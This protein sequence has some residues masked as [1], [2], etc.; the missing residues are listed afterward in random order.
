MNY[1]DRAMELALEPNDWVERFSDLLLS[2]P[3]GA[4]LVVRSQ[5]MDTPRI[6]VTT[7][8]LSPCHFLVDGRGFPIFSQIYADNQLE[9]DT[10]CNSADT[11]DV[12]TKGL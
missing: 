10:F 8:F 9:S 3:K 2:I 5:A 7:V 12:G 1:G 6:S 11:F 4:P